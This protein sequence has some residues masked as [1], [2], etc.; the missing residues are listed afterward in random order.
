MYTPFFFAKAIV[1][2]DCD[3]TNTTKTIR[4]IDIFFIS[5]FHSINHPLQFY[6]RSEA[7]CD[8]FIG[9]A[10]TMIYDII[11][12]PSSIRSAATS[13]LSL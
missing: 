4:N 2:K 12:N 10:R 7:F 11:Q 1:E 6:S 3:S 13:A 5:A 8:H 9:K